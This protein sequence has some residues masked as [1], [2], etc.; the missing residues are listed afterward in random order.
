MAAA[1]KVLARLREFATEITVKGKDKGAR[2]TAMSSSSFFLT[3]GAYPPP[4][5][6]PEPRRPAPPPPKIPQWAPP[7][8][9][10][11]RAYNAVDV[12]KVELTAIVYAVW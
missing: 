4:P 9:N 2:I 11:L 1:E 10:K 5:P 12:Q 8:E 6:P 7:T 3:D